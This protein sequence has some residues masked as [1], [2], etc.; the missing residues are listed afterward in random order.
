MLEEASEKLIIWPW[1]K[2]KQSVKKWVSRYLSSFTQTLKN[3]LVDEE[4]AQGFFDALKCYFFRCHQ[5]PPGPGVCPGG[6]VAP[7]KL[8]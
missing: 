2:A 5:C 1:K 8:F 3:A 7:A 4:D 6:A